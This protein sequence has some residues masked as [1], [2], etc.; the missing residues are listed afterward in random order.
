MKLVPD[1][2]RFINFNHI[3][4]D[5]LRW[6]AGYIYYR[7]Y[8]KGEYICHEGDDSDCFFGIITGLVSIRKRLV[9]RER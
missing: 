9:I 6:A 2:K 4:D 7:H 1:L 8:K 5:S 3:D